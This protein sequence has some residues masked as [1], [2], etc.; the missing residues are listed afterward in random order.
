ML[1]M[2]DQPSYGANEDIIGIL[3]RDWHNIL[4]PI[5]VP[6]LSAEHRNDFCCVKVEE[7]AE[8]WQLSVQ[9]HIS[10]FLRGAAVRELEGIYLLTSCR[11]MI[12]FAGISGLRSK[13]PMG[14]APTTRI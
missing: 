3:L 10:C 6:G 1:H 8:I 7:G 13:R 5:I 11:T 14:L 4:V 12:V 2:S 9:L